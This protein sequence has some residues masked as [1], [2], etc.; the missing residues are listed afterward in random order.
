MKKFNILFIALTLVLTTS[1]SSDD[2]EPIVS[3]SIIGSWTGTTLDYSGKT[4]T[5]VQGQSITSDYIGEAYDMD[6]VLTFAENPNVIVSEG[7]YSIKLTNTTLG[8]TSVQNIENIEFL[9]AETW[10]QK[11]NIITV[12]DNGET[13]DFTIVELTENTL[14]LS[15]STEEDL[16]EQGVSIIATINATMTFS[17]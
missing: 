14:K 16:S 10:E 17:R 15:A 13:T 4:V 2:S 1:C 7:N 8:Q 3:G 6:Y 9:E 5:T 12:T 11:D